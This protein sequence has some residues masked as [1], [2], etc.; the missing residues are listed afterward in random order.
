L[1]VKLALHEQ[2]PGSS[3]LCHGCLGSDIGLAHVEV[4]YSHRPNPNAARI[5][6][7]ELVICSNCIRGA[8]DSLDDGNVGKD[9][10][11]KFTSHCR[12]TGPRIE[13]AGG[14]LVDIEK[15][16]LCSDC[17]SKALGLIE[18]EEAELEKSRKLD[19][20]KTVGARA[21]ARVGAK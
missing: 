12:I 15:L 11:P 4:D 9:V 10:A 20:Q 19:H 14:Y 21:R 18:A 7:A 17:L 5:V 1:V 13:L 8:K 2:R 3:L 16:T 6:P